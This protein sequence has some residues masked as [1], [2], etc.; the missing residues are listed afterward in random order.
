MNKYLI[1]ALIATNFITSGCSDVELPIIS[2]NST[3]V[4][5][6]ESI[7]ELSKLINLEDMQVTSATWA[8]GSY[9]VP[10]SDSESFLPSE[11]LWWVKAVLTFPDAQSL[12]ALVGKCELSYTLNDA[13]DLPTDDT[14]KRLTSNPA[15]ITKVPM[16]VYDACVFE[17]GV[18]SDG[19][20]V[21]DFEKAQVLLKISNN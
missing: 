17:G 8:T 12:T 2:Q 15:F 16:Q 14:V 6:S 11:N 9:N 13:N 1:T 19:V 10:G 3:D 20:M 21:V 18:L 4:E 5:Y 7:A